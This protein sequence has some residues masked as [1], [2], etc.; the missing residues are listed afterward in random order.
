MKG[1]LQTLHPAL[2]SLIPYF[3]TTLDKY[4]CLCVLNIN[5]NNLFTDELQMSEEDI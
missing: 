1:F 2:V 4:V 3:L 5:I